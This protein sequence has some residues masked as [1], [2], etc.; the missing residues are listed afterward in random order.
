MPLPV[1]LFLLK[2]IILRIAALKKAVYCKDMLCFAPVSLLLKSVYHF[3]HLHHHCQIKNINGWI[4]L[5][6]MW[7]TSRKALFLHEYIKMFLY[8]VLLFS[9][10]IL[11]KSN[12]QLQM[13]GFWKYPVIWRQPWNQVQGINSH[14]INVLFCWKICL[15]VVAM[16]RLTNCM[17]VTSMHVTCMQRGFRVHKIMCM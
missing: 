3:I 6:N 1:F 4:L 11:W 10:H 13:V 12:L 17:L 15:L 14:F 9:D 8:F 16:H 2:I 7:P 5:S